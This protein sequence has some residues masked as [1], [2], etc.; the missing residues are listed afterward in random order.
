PEFVGHALMVE[1]ALD[2]EFEVVPFGKRGEGEGTLLVAPAVPVDGNFRRLARLEGEA[3]WLF[4][5]VAPHIVGDGFGAEDGDAL[6]HLLL[7]LQPSD[8]AG[9][10]LVPK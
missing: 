8:A 1:V 10:A 3:R 9:A 4:E 2:G 7:L 5:G 6:G